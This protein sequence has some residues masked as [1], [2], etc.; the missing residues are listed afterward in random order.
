ML[1]THWA[2]EYETK[3]VQQ[4]CSHIYTGCIPQVELCVEI[5][6][7]VKY[8]P[9]KCVNLLYNKYKDWRINLRHKFVLCP[10][11]N[12]YC[13]DRHTFPRKVIPWRTSLGYIK[14]IHDSKNAMYTY[15]CTETKTVYLNNCRCR[16]ATIQGR[17][18]RVGVHM[19]IQCQY[20]S[21]PMQLCCV[22]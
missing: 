17:V 19:W 9:R 22:W 1:E 2:V 6:I 3:Y 20:V 10:Q 11:N 8:P 14:Y 13:L 12:I 7:P 21:F 18:G 15:K 4:A 5:Q 16:P